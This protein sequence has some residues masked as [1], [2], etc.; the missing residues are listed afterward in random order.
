MTAA[1]A[2]L[3][4]TA[5]A[6]HFVHRLEFVLRKTARTVGVELGEVLAHTLGAA[7]A[8][9][10]TALIA[11]FLA[12]FVHGL[13]FGLREFAITIGVGG[14]EHFLAPR[15][16][17]FGIDHAV[18]I[19]IHS[20]E[21][22]IAMRLHFGL[23]HSAVAIGVGIMAALM[24]G[25]RGCAGQCQRGDRKSEESLVHGISPSVWRAATDQGSE[26][27]NV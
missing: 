7:V 27:R 26:G 5:F 16:A 20:G 2:A 6:A 9:R 8:A 22:L 19:G 15:L 25:E 18:A 21:H 4:R 13:H 10:F 24:L 23:G 11:A 1:H 14:S 3:A 17:I 12:R